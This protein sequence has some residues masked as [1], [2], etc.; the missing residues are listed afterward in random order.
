VYPCVRPLVYA[1]ESVL[2][3]VNLHQREYW[4]SSAATASGRRAGTFTTV[5]TIA[6]WILVTL[7]LAGFTNAVRRE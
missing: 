5:A 6:G 7:V 1:L 4:Q 2:P 3:V